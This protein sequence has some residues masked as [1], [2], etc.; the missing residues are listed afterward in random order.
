MAR[1]LVCYGSGK[2][3]LCGGIKLFCKRLNLTVKNP[4]PKPELFSCS[5]RLETINLFDR[6]SPEEAR[7]SDSLKVQ[8]ASL[9]FFQSGLLLRCFYCLSKSKDVHRLVHESK[10]SICDLHSENDCTWFDILKAHSKEEGETELECPNCCEDVHFL[11]TILP[12]GHVMCH[13]CAFQLQICPW[14]TF[15]IAAVIRL[16]SSGLANHYG[17]GQAGA[18]MET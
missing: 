8:L 6:L 1:P 2:K 12:C 13:K 11:H 5:D 18:P 3:R 14:C 10:I 7:R 9:G 4:L 15:V 17:K 16:R